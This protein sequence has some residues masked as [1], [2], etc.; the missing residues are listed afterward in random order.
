MR[1]PEH[2]GLPALFPGGEEGR[3]LRFEHHDG[4]NWTYAVELRDERTW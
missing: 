3:L 1:R 4:R 2:V